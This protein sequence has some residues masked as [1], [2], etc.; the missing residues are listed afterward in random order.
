METDLLLIPMGTTYREMRA[1]ALAADAAGFAG[2]WTW[3]HLRGTD[4]G[5]T[6]EAWTTLTGLAE[7]VARPM[8][9]PLVLNVINRHPGVLA[10][11]AATLQQ[12]SGGRLILGLGAGGSRAT[13]YAREQ[14]AIGQPVEA[15]RARAAR[16][17]E[18]IQVM[19]RLWAGDSR[20]FQ[21]VHYQ[22]DRP[23]GFLR[24]DP[25]PPI[26]VGA[27]GMAMAKIAGQ[28]ADGLNTQATH[29]RLDEMVATARETHAAS[30][31]DPA[32]FLVTVFAGMSEAWLRPG[33]RNRVALERLGVARLILLVEPPYNLDAV[34]A[35]GQMLRGA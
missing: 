5:T 14:D 22:L 30:G 27:F 20:S 6:P 4:G 31:R 26:V 34:A 19:K 3:D 17:V 18:A 16:V 33:S 10:N 21:G 8:I 7:A 35:A 9:G 28:Y 25:P 15:D 29:P 13:P 24:A 12:V 1:A 11:M 2:L 23:S 32:S